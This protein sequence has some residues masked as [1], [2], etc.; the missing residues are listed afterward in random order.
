MARLSAQRMRRSHRIV[1]FLI[2]LLAVATFV[3]GV[4]QLVG[5][6]K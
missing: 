4:L 2:A 1:F 3:F 5:A 6:A